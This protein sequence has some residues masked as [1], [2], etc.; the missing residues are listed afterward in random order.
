[1]KGLGLEIRSLRKKKQMTLV[2]LSKLC[3]L[4][5]STLSRIEND[6][7]TGTLDSH[8]KI[9]QALGVALPELYKSSLERM[10]APKE[11]GLKAKV[12][13]FSH[14][15]GAVSEIL[16]SGIFQKK[17]L[18]ILLKL[19]P[20]G[21]TETE[22]FPASTE[23]F[24]YVFKGK[25]EVVLSQQSNTV[26]EGERIYFDASLPHYFKNVSG[27]EALCLSVMTPVSA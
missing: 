21:K 9:C 20:K 8:M 7:I 18:P 14:S 11:T 10:N 24:I 27:K 13:R 15:S 6:D 2:E 3:G 5:Q 4:D 25:L 22:E 1:M 16:T 19:K 23:R 12:E 17:M 26:C